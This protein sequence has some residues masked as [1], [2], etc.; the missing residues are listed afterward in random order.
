MCGNTLPMRPCVDMG[1]SWEYIQRRFHGIRLQSSDQP[2]FAV[3]DDYPSVKENPKEVL[4]EI[5]WYLE[6]DVPPDLR[7]CHLQLIVKPGE[8][9]ILRDWSNPKYGLNGVPYNPDAD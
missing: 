7:V 1:V 6:N 8:V 2:K 5:L 3:L 4:D 9:R